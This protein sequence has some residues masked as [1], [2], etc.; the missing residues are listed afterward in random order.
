[1]PVVSRRR[2]LALGACAL[3]AFARGDDPP[4]VAPSKDLI[5]PE[6]KEAA[7][8]GLYWLVQTQSADGSFGDRA[9]YNGSVA[10]TSLA[11]LALLAGGHTPGRTRF[12]DAVSKALANVL[13]KEQRGSHPGFLSNAG[14]P[15]QFS[16]YNHGFATLFLAEAHGM[17]SDRELRTKLRGTLERA[18]QLIVSSQNSEG[19]WRY[20]PHP[21]QADISVTIC[22][23]M[24]LRSAKNAGL[25]VPKSTRDACLKYVRGCQNA[26]GGFS[27]F[28]QG[29]GLGGNSAFARSAAGVVALYSAG[30]Y[31]GP[32]VEKG[33]KYLGQT[34]SNAGGFRRIEL[35]EMHYYYGLYY[36]AQAMWTAGG[37]WW[38]DWFPIA[39]D[40]LLGRQR[41]GRWS[42][43]SVCDHYATAMA[44]IVLNIPSNYLPI[45][46]K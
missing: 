16:M 35:P 18:V 10:V 45:L 2:L 14:A 23:I 44:C 27:Y 28:R 29:V 9:H 37:R 34:R 32:E 42:D 8:R 43:A 19:G 3:P 24:A 12:G 25:A 13:S 26:D 36:A 30:I 39:R 38:D 17:V 40:E 11:G 7:E 1:M 15:G 22:Q 4:E 46:Q 33:L 20:D 21:N 41:N 5:T 6:A 31:S